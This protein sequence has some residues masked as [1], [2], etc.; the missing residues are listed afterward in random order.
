V[1]ADANR[2]GWLLGTVNGVGDLVASAGVGL[3][4][5]VAAPAAAFA[6]AALVMAL[7]AALVA[8]LVIRGGA[9]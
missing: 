1:T 6:A 4:W 3:L 7:G 2:P 8:G 9:R 5:T